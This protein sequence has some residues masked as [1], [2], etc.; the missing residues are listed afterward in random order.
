MENKFFRVQRIKTQLKRFIAIPFIFA[1]IV[2][3]IFSQPGKNSIFATIKYSLNERFIHAISVI[4]KPFQFVSDWKNSILAYFSV[5]DENIKLKQE[6]EHLLKWKSLALKL[7]YEQKELK[8]LLNYNPVEKGKERV[9]HVL[10]DYNSPFSQSVIL[11]GGKDIGI[12][13]GSVLLTNNGLYGYVIHVNETAS[14]ALKI[15]D[16]FSRVPVLVGENN[17]LCIMVGENTEKPKLTALPEDYN[18]QDGDFVLTAGAVG[19]YPSGIPVG[20]IKIKNETYYV[21]PFENEKHIEFVRVVDFGLDGLID[22][23]EKKAE[24]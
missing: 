21:E 23:E 17:V 24:K 2:F 3:L 18:I 7:S 10:I 11:D 20:K 14:R 4:S 9:V 6:N 13:K 19:V 12:K 5:Y 1:A 15:T 16:Y 22:Q 8:K